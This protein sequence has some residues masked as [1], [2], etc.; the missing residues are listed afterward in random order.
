M[1]TFHTNVEYSDVATKYIFDNFFSV[2][3]DQN[4]E[5][6]FFKMFE[7]HFKICRMKF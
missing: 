7:F 1:H 6:F 3:L 5:I 2:K 4:P